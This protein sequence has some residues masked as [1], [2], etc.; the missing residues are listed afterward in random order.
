MAVPCLPG[1]PRPAGWHRE[2]GGGGSAGTLPGVI[3]ALLTHAGGCLQGSRDLP[4]PQLPGMQRQDHGEH[5]RGVCWGLAAVEGWVWTSG[6]LTPS[7]LHHPHSGMVW[8]QCPRRGRTLQGGHICVSAD[9][10]SLPLGSKNCP[11]A[12][13][14]DFW[15]PPVKRAGSE[16]ISLSFHPSA[17]IPH[18]TADP[19]GQG[20]PKCCQRDLWRGFPSLLSSVLR[21]C[22]GVLGSPTLPGEQGWL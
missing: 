16:S 13:G 5:P 15:K 21:A 6:I 19:Q 3:N 22:E 20:S 12:E 18:P 1:C 9:G 10:S 17:N 7:A 14:K 4:V 11:G 8:L 2:R